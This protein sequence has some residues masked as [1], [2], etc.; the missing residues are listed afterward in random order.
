M[1][2]AQLAL[3]VTCTAEHEAVAIRRAL[4]YRRQ[5]GEI[6]GDVASRQGTEAWANPAMAA[7]S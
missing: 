1:C 4:R 6:G 7:G 3:V 2:P 5:A